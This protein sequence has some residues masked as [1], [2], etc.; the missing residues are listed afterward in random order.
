MKERE[1][2]ISDKVFDIRFGW[3]I[4]IDIIKDAKL[5]IKVSFDSLPLAYYYSNEKNEKQLL[6]HH[7]YELKPVD[8]VVLVRDN[9]YD[10]WLQ[11]VFHMKKNGKYICWF[12]SKTLE[13]ARDSIKIVEWNQMKEVE[14]AEKQQIV[15]LTLEDISNGKGVG[16]P[17]HLIR[18]K[19]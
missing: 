7:E 3:G 8:R 16:V 19:K 13:E 4:V 17:P 2:K 9:D 18:I 6:S 1:F 11:G 15:E 14:D 5:P 10:E 12:N